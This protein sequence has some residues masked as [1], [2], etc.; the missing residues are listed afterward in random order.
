M[1]KLDPT[2]PGEI[3][4]A[5]WISHLQSPARKASLS[6]WREMGAP[7]VSR[8]V[9]CYDGVETGDSRGRFL[10]PTATLS[11]NDAYG[12]PSTTS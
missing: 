11:D 3:L 8:P 2:A 7:G 10:V 9:A 5:P 4:R 1:T 12:L 6:R